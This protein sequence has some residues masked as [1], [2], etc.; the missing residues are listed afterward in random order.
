MNPGLDW[1]RRSLSLGLHRDPIGPSR[2]P[3]ECELPGLTAAL[4]AMTADC[5]TR[6]I[7]NGE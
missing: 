3:A 7:A 1:H 5:K 2:V 4:Q 6:Q